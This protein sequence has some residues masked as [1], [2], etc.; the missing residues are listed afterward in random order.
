MSDRITQGRGAGVAAG[1]RRWASRVSAGLL[2]GMAV[3]VSAGT[4]A[5]DQL[6]LRIEGVRSDQ[7]VLRIGVFDRSGSF[8]S[9]GRVAG[10]EVMAQRGY[11]IVEIPGLE[12]GEYAIALYHD[13]DGDGEFDTN[14]LGLPLEGYGFSNDAPVSF[15]PPDFEE[16]AF[17]VGNTG[18][19]TVLQMRY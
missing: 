11:V 16:A 12:P 9:A 15:G 3:A 2:V 13:E 4:A 19:H 10:V 5:A 18:T 1:W 14:F 7:G 17:V 8:P 6:T